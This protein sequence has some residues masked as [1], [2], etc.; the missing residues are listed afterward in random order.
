M[1]PPQES[2]RGTPWRTSYQPVSYRLD[3]KLGTEA[4]FKAMVEQCNAT[5]VGIIADV[6]LHQTTGSDV[7]AGEQTGVAGTR[8]NGTTGDYP[9]FTG[10]SN[11]YPDGVTAADFHDYNNGANISDYKNQQEVQEGRLSSMWDFDTSS[12]KVRQIQSDYLTKLYNMGVQGFRMDAVKHINNE[13]MKAIKDQMARKVGTSADDIYWIQEVIG[14]ANEAPGIQP[15]NY[16]GTGT[17]TQFDYKS[18]LNA[19]FKG[20]IAALK[21]LSTR[22]GDLSQNPNAIESKDANVFVPNWDTARNDG[23][24]TYKNGSMYALANAFM[25]AY[26]YGTSRLLSDYKYDVNDNG[27]PGATETAV[28]DVDFSQTCSTKD[29]DWNC[30]QRWTTTRGMIAF[31]NYVHGTAAEHWQDDGAN[32]IAFSCSGKGFVAINN[33][34]ESKEAEYSTTM[35][36][37]EYCDV[38]AIQ[39]CS[40]TVTVSGGKIKASVPAMQ[41]IAIYGGATKATHPDFKVAVD[42]STPDVV[43]PNNTVKPDDQTT[44]VWYKSTK[45]WGKVFVHHGAGSDWTAVPGEQME[46]RD[47]QGYYKKTIDTKGEEHQI[48]FNDGGDWDSDNGKNYL[49]AKG[50]TQVGVENGALSV[51]N[52]EAVTGQTRL[53]VHYKPASDEFTANRGVYV[54][55]KDAAGAELAGQH[56]AFT[57]EDCYGKVAEPKFDGTFNNLNFIITT[58]GWNK[59]GGDRSAK[60]AADGT[61]EVWVDGTGADDVTLDK[62]PADYRCTA[63]KV[64][65]TIHYMRNDGLYFN[66]ADADT[67]VPQWDV[68]T[69][70]FNTNGFAAKFKSHDDWGG[71]ALASF[72]NYAYP[73][74]ADGTSDF[75]MLRRYGADEWKRKDGGDDDI[76]MTASAL[77]FDK[78]TNS[79]KAEVW[80]L[81]DD[82]TVY[83]AR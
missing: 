42:P 80:M 3:S 65:V 59:F 69:W 8:Y 7:A 52:P 82:S 47:A 58:D 54:W 26:D 40:K 35:P 33:S 77:V 46:G 62:A 5:G 56:L 67:K 21:D 11:R 79:A 1:S 19:K 66:A 36:D 60:V 53:L 61:A 50:I 38:Y 6:V 17:V 45:K 4:E 43:I 24:I 29:A 75:G 73:A 81:Q 12:E 20:K 39:D 28:P 30:Q 72:N 68:W 44:T 9:G 10:E 51:G 18:D 70:N 41:A 48:C 55:G 22:I 71:L 32:S 14:N 78:A 13:D 15:R 34:T 63:Q 23:A 37:G 57:G 31:H 25:L 74:A 76:K 83:T 49:I 16:L 64:D 2:I 27:A